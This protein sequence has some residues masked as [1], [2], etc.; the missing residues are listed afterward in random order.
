MNL[1]LKPSQVIF[2]ILALIIS[3]MICGT[4]AHLITRSVSS[5]GVDG[6]GAVETTTYLQSHPVIVL[7]LS[8]VITSLFVLMMFK[9]FNEL[10]PLVVL[11]SLIG[12]IVL[13]YGFTIASAA[14]FF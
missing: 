1:S 8:L 7:G 4:L 13:S 3:S 10:S 2:L 11:V 5:W 12:V 14:V 9:L 6:L